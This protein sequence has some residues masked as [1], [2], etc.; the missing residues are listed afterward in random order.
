MT[1]PATLLAASLLG[2]L[3]LVLGGRCVALRQALAKAGEDA[4]A[5][6]RLEAAL[7]HRMRVMANFAEYV[8]FALVQLAAIELVVHKT[9][10]AFAL[11]AL[12][13]VARV[14]HAWGY[15][16]SEGR[17]AGR[18]WGTLLTWIVIAAQSLI[19]LYAVLMG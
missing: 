19:G 8:P 1:T 10:L 6:V 7:A 18:Y 17:S 4:E 14:L 13:V 9:L 3:L 15:S 2:I 16:R 12:L 11:A 5:R